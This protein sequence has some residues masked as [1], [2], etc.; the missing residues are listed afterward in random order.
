MMATKA[1]SMLAFLFSGI[2]HGEIYDSERMI[3]WAYDENSSIANVYSYEEG[4]V[5]RQIPAPKFPLYIPGVDRGTVSWKSDDGIK[6]TNLA[7]D[8]AEVAEIRFKWEEET[9][10]EV[11]R[12]PLFLDSDNM[13]TWE[14]E[15]SE[16]TAEAMLVTREIEKNA[17]LSGIKCNH[18]LPSTLHQLSGLPRMNVLFLRPGQLLL[19][20]AEFGGDALKLYLA[21]Y[22][23]E[24]CKFDVIY[25]TNEIIL[26]LSY[27]DEQLF[28][29][30]R[31]GSNGFLLSFFDV[32]GFPA[33]KKQ[34]KIEHAEDIR[35]D[36]GFILVRTREQTVS[37][38][39]LSNDR[40]WELSGESLASSFVG[41]S[42]SDGWIA[43]LQKN[44]V[45]F[46]RLESDGWKQDHVLASSGLQIE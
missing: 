8:S 5:L 15:E 35:V 1:V 29:L 37:L 9:Q 26:E 19:S 46:F 31:G 36:N 43:I 23:Y 13:V 44:K 7:Y 27:H 21:I 32:S 40:T 18:V 25:E 34:E 42:A 45:V 10:T 16:N 14:S 28:V 2:L 6:A 24:N 41:F 22:D 30:E 11:Y 3:V 39:N 33:L 20:F 4:K 38:R 17:V 12:A